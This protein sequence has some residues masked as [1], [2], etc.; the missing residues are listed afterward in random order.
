MVQDGLRQDLSYRQ[1]VMIVIGGALGIGLVLGTGSAL[2]D[3]GP[4]AILIAYLLMSIVAY[5]VMC[6]VGEMATFA[7]L[8]EGFSGYASR[9]VDPC[10]G[11]AVGYTYWL[12]YL[13]V[14]PNQITAGALLVQYWVDKTIVN[15]GV[16][17]TVFIFLIVMFNAFGG[18]E[19][20]GKL[21]YWLSLV[22]IF[23][24][25]ALLIMLVVIA[26]GGA[27]DHDFKGFRY[28]N[29]PG[30]FKELTKPLSNGIVY[31]LEGNI[32]RFAAFVKVLITATF[33]Y[34]GMELIGVT[35]GEAKDPHKTIPR[36]I[37]STFYKVTGYYIAS[38]IAIGMCIPFD[39]SSLIFSE[40]QQDNQS[41]GR[42]SGSPFIVA[43]QNAKLR[44]LPHIINFA[45]LIFILASGVAGLYIST[46]T[47][48]GLAKGNL[49]P[50]IFRKVNSKGVP[51][52]AMILS[53]ASM[54]FAYLNIS[55]GSEKVFRHLVNFV[56]VLG[57]LAW[58]TILY[59]HISFIRALQAQG[60]TRHMLPWKSPLLPYGSYCALAF[61][62]I[63]VII[64]DF[65][66]FLGEIDWVS[67]IVGNISLP[68]FVMLILVYKIFVRSRRVRSQEADL[69]DLSVPQLSETKDE[70]VGQPKFMSILQRLFRFFC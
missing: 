54:T 36:A 5:V 59:T 32:G 13:I 38:I 70:S 48:Y 49:A 35:V 16:W 34:L 67:I 57:L 63:L 60:W 12:N 10:L 51:M 40:N 41:N 7:P 25:W 62:I 66:C 31:Y 11:F 1:M 17:I 14:T 26:F 28:W 65:S 21:E 46:R 2:A 19:S 45:F 24:V 42:V 4:G 58:I 33:S 43:L 50:K 8:A 55:A 15:P 30:A 18:V 64:K 52:N 3:A 29:N 53:S 23:T 61:C 6:A 56:A 37:Q 69:V 68:L 22:K 27:P 20:F 9:Y 47:L 44:T 39:D